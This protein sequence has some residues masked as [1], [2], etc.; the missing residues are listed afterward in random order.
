[1]PSDVS[2]ASAA[3]VALTELINELGLEVRYSRKNS[4]QV[5]PP[6]K[7]LQTPEKALQIRDGPRAW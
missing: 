3:L 2:E 5:L 4:T 1:M 6:E 7:A